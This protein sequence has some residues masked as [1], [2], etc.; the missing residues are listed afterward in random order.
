MH[1]PI[2]LAQRALRT[3]LLLF[4]AAMG[5]IFLVRL[6][7]G[8]FSD[9][10]EMD[11]RYAQA[12]RGE[13]QAQRSGK[14]SVYDIAAETI[15]GWI[16]DDFGLSRQYQMP[17]ADLLAARVP[18]SALL[19]GK[20][21]AGGWLLAVCAVLPVSALRGSSVLWGAPFTVLLSIPAAAMA[22]ACIVSNHGGPVMVLSLLI[23]AREF[24]FLR[25]LL[26]DAWRSPHLLQ[27]RAQGVPGRV[28][29][30]A[31]ILPNIASQLCALMT[32]SLVT[33]LGVLIPI[34][35]IFSVPGLGQLA[36]SAVMNRDLP[37]LTASS[38]LMACMVAAAGLI[39]TRQG[40]LEAL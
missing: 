29:L 33:A 38:L 5:T 2:A 15:Q 9:I 10:R 13:M 25:S 37:V 26:Q 12:A 16:H 20:G 3:L 22:T 27:G 40:T 28:L 39:A 6:A 36:W 19:L 11:A 34:E 18:V 21:I 1:W 23:A 14:T 7:P 17:V 31:H 32:L 8:F 4:F 30:A 35:V 24:K